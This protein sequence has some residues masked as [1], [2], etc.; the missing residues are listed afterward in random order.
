VVVSVDA[1]LVAQRPPAQ[2]AAGPLGIADA[3]ARNL[4]TGGV[5]DP[6]LSSAHASIAAVRHAYERL[7]APSRGPAVTA[8]FA[9]ARA[10]VNSPAFTSAYTAARQKARPAGLPPEE[11]TVDEELKKQVDE[12]RATLAESKQAL[13]A[14]PGGNPKDRAQILSELKQLEDDLASPATLKAMRDEI[15]AR[16]ASDNGG[17]SDRVTTWNAR[18]PMDPRDFVKRQLQQFLEASGRVDFALPITVVKSPAGAIVGFAAPRERVFESW[19]EVECLLA[20][21]EMVS[22]ARTAA[23]AWLK[24]L[25]R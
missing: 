17:V 18:Y 12:K 22:A 13:A 11:L 5:R 20:G 19:I 21:Q 7:P 15:E 23:E 3:T 24:E 9:W 8:A 14:V 2:T 10:Y 1:A 16:R 6:Q 4:V 25:S